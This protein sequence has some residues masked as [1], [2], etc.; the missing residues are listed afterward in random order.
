[1]QRFLQS[2]GRATWEE[3]MWH[4]FM[5]TLDETN[6]SEL[7]LLYHETL[8]NSGVTVAQIADGGEKA[9]LWPEMQASLKER[10]LKAFSITSE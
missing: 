10:A 9:H 4:R 7:L 6:R 1:M 5:R 2:T 8:R 3:A